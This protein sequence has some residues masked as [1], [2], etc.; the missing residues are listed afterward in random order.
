VGFSSEQPL[1]TLVAKTSSMTFRSTRACS[2]GAATR[3]AAT[4]HWLNTIVLAE[5]LCPFAAAPVASPTKLRM[6]ASE[7]TDVASLTAELTEEADLLAGSGAEDAGAPE[8]E[9]M[10]LVL[11]EVAWCIEWPQLVSM[12]WTLQAEAIAARGHGQT[13]QIVLFHPSAVRSTYAAGP[14]DAADYALRSPFPVVQLLREVDLLDA[15]RAH[16]DSGG[17]PA[18]NAARLRA[19]GEDRCRERL[20]ACLAASASLR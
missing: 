13:L 16:P 20:E 5:R 3:L 11:P 2:S 15:V 17:I 9:T 1:Q 18:R 10:L 14:A 4:R 8:H 7:A 19:L 12:S 6:R